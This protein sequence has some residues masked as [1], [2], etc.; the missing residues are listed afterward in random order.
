MTEYFYWL[1]LKFYQY[2]FLYTVTPGIKKKPLEN[3]FRLMLFSLEYL[4]S[5]ESAEYGSIRLWIALS[6]NEKRK[7]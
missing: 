1:L 5:H 2:A 4:Y 3:P 7:V 6:I